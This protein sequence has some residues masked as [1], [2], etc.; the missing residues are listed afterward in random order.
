MHSIYC[1]KHF[2]NDYLYF[3]R[4]SALSEM[5]SQLEIKQDNYGDFCNVMQYFSI[6]LNKDKDTATY[7]VM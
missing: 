2:S 5:K 3:L 4:V 7:N 1:I 6:N